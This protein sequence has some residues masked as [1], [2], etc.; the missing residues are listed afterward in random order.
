MQAVDVVTR[1][2]FLKGSS[3]ITSREVFPGDAVLQGP[4]AFEWRTNEV[5]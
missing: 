3:A 5:N 1:G 2:L 4:L